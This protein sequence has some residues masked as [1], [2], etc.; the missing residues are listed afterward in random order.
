MSTA[1]TPTFTSPAAAPATTATA[2]SSR[3][4]QQRKFFVFM[5]FGRLRGEAIAQVF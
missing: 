3:I 5:G 4:Q 1:A 2:P